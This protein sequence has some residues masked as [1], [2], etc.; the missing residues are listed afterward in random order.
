MHHKMNLKPE[1]MRMIRSGKKTIELRLYDEKRK[2][3]RPG[4]TICF[5]GQNEQDSLTVRVRQLYVFDS[6]E[7]LYQKL[8]LLECGYT[9]ENVAVARYQ[10]MEQYYPQ[11]KQA[12]YGVVGIRVEVIEP[13]TV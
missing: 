12:K 8:P 7:E 13:Q 3:I 10:D 5:T 2:K 4:D 1:P 11:E 6:F 9:P